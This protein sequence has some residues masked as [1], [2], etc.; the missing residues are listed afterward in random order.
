MPLRSLRFARFLSTG[1]DKSL[2]G[3]IV[4]NT[5]TTRLL[6]REDPLSAYLPDLIRDFPGRKP[7]FHLKIAWFVL[8][9][10][11][12]RDLSGRH[13]YLTGLPA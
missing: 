3:V 4:S 12:L 10:A 13:M 11:C 9:A 2:F 7:L 8:P 1:G 6:R 5:A